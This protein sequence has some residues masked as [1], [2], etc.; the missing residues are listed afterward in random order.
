MLS[1]SRFDKLGN[2]VPEMQIQAHAHSEPVLVWMVRSPYVGFRVVPRRSCTS[3]Q[4]A[5]VSHHRDVD[6]RLPPAIV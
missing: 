3:D 5:R 6:H 1:V 2:V 4:R